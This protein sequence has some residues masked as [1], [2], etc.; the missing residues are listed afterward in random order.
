VTLPGAGDYVIFAHVTAHNT[1]GVG[2]GMGCGLFAD[3][4]QAGGGGGNSIAAGAT[5]EVSAVGAL[6]LRGPVVVTMKCDT[7]NHGATT[8]D[9][10]DVT[11]RVHNLG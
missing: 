9:L 8:F 2:V 6:S 10:S 1:G 3:G 11:L 5:A 7:D 4:G